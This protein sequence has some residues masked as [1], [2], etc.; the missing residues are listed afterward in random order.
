MKVSA[1]KP[2]LPHL[3]AVL[4]FTVIS[5]LYFYPV[6]EGRK[7]NAHDTKVYEGS[8][9]EI[10]D[11]REQYGKE[12]LWTNSMF[13]GMPAY[14]ISAKYPGN[15][16]K[17]LDNF[18]KLYRTPV[19]ALFL[20]MLG[21]YI[22]L[23]FCRVNPWL[24]LGGAIAY[25]FASYLFVS[26]S[27][28]HN[29]KAYAMA[30][31][32]PVVG[33]VIYSFRKHALT[34]GILFAL[35]MSLELMANHFQITY[36]TGMIV[37][38]FGI[39]ELVDAIKRKTIPSFLKTMGI[40]VAAALIA[41]SVNFASLYSTWEYAKESTRGKSELTKAGG[42]NETGLDKEYITQWSYGID[43]SFTFLIPNFRGGA[44]A[45]FPN[46]SETVKIL[47]KNNMGQAQGQVFTYWGKQPSTSG[48]VYFG[49]V[50]LFLFILGLLIVKGREKWWILTA[51]L[52]SLF[53]SWGKNFMPLTSLFIDF[54]PGYDKFR[55]VSMTLVIAGVCVPLL[56]VLALNAIMEGTVTKEKA[57]KSLLPAALI[58]GGIA[59]IFF[60][61]PG[62]AGSLLRPDEKLLPDSLSWLRDA[63]IADRKTM[64]RAD[65]LR[66]AL[67]IA[68]GAALLWFF[69]KEK[70]KLR[71][72]LIGLPLLFLIDQIPV[73][74]RYLGP[75]NF[76][77]KRE[78]VNSFAPTQADKEI[79]QDKG[80]YRVLNLTVSTFNDA[81]TSYH[82][83][84][85][86]GYSGV[87]MKRY[88]ELIESSLT[89]DINSLITSLR[90]ASSW[91]DAEGVM[92]NL[93]AL[94]MLNTKYI[95]ID[96]KALPLLNSFAIGNAWLVERV[97]LVENADAE[98]SAIKTSDPLYE[99]VVDRRFADMLPVTDNRGSDS[100]TVFLASYEPNLLTYKSSL[101]SDRVAVFSEIYYKYGWQ[102]YIDD[103]PAEHFRTDY[104][105]RGMLLPAGSHTITFRFE[106]R[107]YMI[108][109]RISLAG[110]LILLAFLAL[111]AF[112][113]FK[114]RRR[115]A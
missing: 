26:L 85:I 27:A 88:Q 68:G 108:G 82:H 44:T 62:L 33:S 104:V 80:K 13:G 58:T 43:E 17:H 78:A 59:F 74:A 2:A 81:S 98:L 9:K 19:A 103:V 113:G 25:G 8:S 14:M 15:L 1:L 28:G 110:S 29:T 11:Y 47:R 112:Q 49:A 5:F 71:Y 72:F 107:S 56:A 54:F 100:D 52:L 73:S 45:P 6:L 60:L 12:P 38:V 83:Q 79:L 96:P 24:A 92:K 55:A 95:I 32:A 114:T 42:T 50:V 102:A 4:V 111:A 31:M 23:L 3:I 115:D 20:S 7:I 10:S 75:L 97:K 61:L 93:N 35:F 37:L 57:L 21:F 84:S 90:A 76:E 53:L 34:G 64:V 36:Y 22:L 70:I 66:S 30:Y 99:A 101:S 48:P 91:E 77:T 46:D 39:F 16:F 69:I 109:N 18:L 89:D 65:A 87:K 51:A 105:L 40:L 106:P 63:M 41:F 86:G 67:L 94:N